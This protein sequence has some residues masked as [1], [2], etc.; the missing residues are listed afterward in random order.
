LADNLTPPPKGGI[1]KQL[2]GTLFTTIRRIRQIPKRETSSKYG[3]YVRNML[4]TERRAASGW[5]GA[6]DLTKCNLA[7]RWVVRNGGAFRLFRIGSSGGFL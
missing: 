1:F 7:S 5:V 4:N 2:H 6:N 3:K